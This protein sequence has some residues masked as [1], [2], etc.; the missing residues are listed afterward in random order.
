MESTL[1]TLHHTLQDVGS[2]KEDVA[3][4][5]IDPTKS[6]VVQLINTGGTNA[7]FLWVVSSQPSQ[8]TILPGET[9]GPVRITAGQCSTW[10]VDCG[11]NK[12]STMEVIAVEAG[13]PTV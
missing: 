11:T 6:I 10:Q 1:D 9:F 4:G 7:I 3:W 5:D 12:T 8:F 13:D 2:S